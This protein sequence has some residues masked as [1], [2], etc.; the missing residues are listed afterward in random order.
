MKQTNDWA[1]S[2]IDYPSSELVS[3]DVVV[4]PRDLSTRSQSPPSDL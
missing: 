4:T 3:V 1:D 2:M